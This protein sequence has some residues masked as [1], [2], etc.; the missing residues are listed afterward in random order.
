[1]YDGKY[2]SLYPPPLKDLAKLAAVPEP[3]ASLIRTVFAKPAPISR[4]VPL[5]DCPTEP[6]ILFAIPEREVVTINPC[7]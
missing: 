3:K 6:H 4:L 1:M 5:T 2:Q 7:C